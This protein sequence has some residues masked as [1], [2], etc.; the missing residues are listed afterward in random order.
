M[1]S[2]RKSPHH[3]Q[4]ARQLA[5]DARQMTGLEPLAF[6]ALIGTTTASIHQWESGVHAPAGPAI[7]LLKLIRDHRAEVIPLLEM[8]MT[9]K[10]RRVYGESAAVDL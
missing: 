1:A 5:R 3:A 2:K 9:S 8:A 10:Q 7:K 4:Q 6:A